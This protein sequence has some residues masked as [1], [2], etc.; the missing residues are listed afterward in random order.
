MNLSI[1]WGVNERNML[2]VMNKKLKVFMSVG[3]LLA[4]TIIII[5]VIFNM[6]QANVVKIEERIGYT[7]ESQTKDDDNKSMNGWLKD[8]MNQFKQ[9]GLDQNLIINDYSVTKTE[10]LG[11]NTVAFDFEIKSQKTNPKL[12][13][14]VDGVYDSKSWSIKCQWVLKYE[15]STDKG[16]TYYKVVDVYDPV[17]KYKNDEFK[18]VEIKKEEASGITKIEKEQYDKK[19]KEAD[20]ISKQAYNNEFM[21]QTKEIQIEAV[22]TYRIYN[23]IC[24][25]SYDNGK[26]WADMPI[27]LEE[28]CRVSDGNS[29]YNKLQDG[30]YIISPERSILAFGGT[31]DTALSIIKSIDKGKTWKKITVDK[32]HEIIYSGRLKFISFP[33]EKVGYIVVTTQRAMSSEAK[34]VFK[35]VDG[36]ESWTRVAVKSEINISRLYQASFLTEKIGFMS[37]VC[38]EQ[39]RLFRTEDGGIT[40]STLEITLEKYYKQPEIPYIENGKMFLVIT[41]GE[42]GDGNKKAMFVS[43]NNGKSFKFEKEVEK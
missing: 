12:E 2:I 36:G 16:K 14:V 32:E 20:A 35:T 23:D 40:W 3:V 9:K 10:L 38:S 6:K 7:V 18:E 17:K 1:V 31:K 34:A 11:S 22:N 41:E 30:S 4:L 29:Y 19:Y 8:Y 25:I 5:L 13:K 24:S 43:E 42:N 37:L 26:N 33:S 15:I 39:P 28:L 27:S 21:Q